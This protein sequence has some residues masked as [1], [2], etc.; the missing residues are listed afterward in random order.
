MD[1]HNLS[2]VSRSWPWLLA[3]AS[4]AAFVLV[5]RLAEPTNM[6]AAQQPASP[7]SV[8]T[9]IVEP[10]SID[11]TRNGLGT[12]L[13]WNMA[14]ISPQV[15]GKVMELPFREGSSVQ[16]GD[17][18]ARIDARPFQAVLDEA[19]AKKSQDESNLIA[20]QKNLSRDET[21]LA[22]GGFA[23]QQSID[24]E[25]AQ[26]D[27][28]KSMIAGDEAS[29]ESA[30]LNLDFATIRAP[31]SGVV[32]LRTVDVG[33]VVTPASSILTIAQIK[34]VAV[35]FSLPQVDLGLVQAA[36]AR[37]SPRV[38][39]LDQDGRNELGVGTLD[40]INNEVD[41][42]TGTIK[43]KA[44]FDNDDRKLWPGAFVQVQVVV[45][46]ESN[47]IAIPSQAVQRGPDGP[48][49]WVVSDRP[50][51]ASPARRDRSDSG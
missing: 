25:R 15:S 47:A 13:A 28:T 21:L 2:L 6:A 8:Q 12:V 50:H 51:R 34:P 9:A 49:L 7:V 24:N 32:G 36:A 42:T 1:R 11:I 17:V 3:A 41:S 14:T 4:A 33:N 16:A 27:A 20:A 46:T 18:L 23:T 29:I 31:F 26:V 19:G 44:R 35:D 39:A 37:G 45:Q 48:F 38:I 5:L 30:Q 43:L 40:A 10:Q 22:K